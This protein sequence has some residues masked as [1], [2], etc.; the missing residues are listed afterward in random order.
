MTESKAKESATT[1]RGADKD[2]DSKKVAKKSKA[3]VSEDFEPRVSA[4]IR[5]KAAPEPDAEP[6]PSKPAAKTS[7]KKAKESPKATEEEEDDGTANTEN[8]Q[9]SDGKVVEGEMLPSGFVLQAEDET[10]VDLNEV[11]KSSG[12]VIFF[13]PKANTPGMFIVDK[14]CTKQAC[15]FRDNYDV[16][17]KA[18]YKIYGCSADNPTPQANWKTKQ[19]F[20]YSLLCDPSTKFLKRFGVFKAPKSVKRSHIIVAKGG[21]VVQV[22]IQISPGDSVDEATKF[23]TGK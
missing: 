22:K 20:Q 15:G 4:R 14:G 1:K 7:K 11:A 3:K 19:K 12:F 16:I 13:Y 23:I 17:K 5:G 8:E 21:K 6:E 18:G 2:A 9:D 10:M